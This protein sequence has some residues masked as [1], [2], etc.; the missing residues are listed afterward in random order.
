MLIP[1][2][3]VTTPIYPV[4]T[5][6]AFVQKVAEGVTSSELSRQK[7]KSKSDAQ[8]IKWNKTTAIP[9]CTAVPDTY[10]CNNKQEN[11]SRL[12]FLFEN[13]FVLHQFQCSYSGTSYIPMYCSLFL[14]VPVLYSNKSR[15]LPGIIMLILFFFS[16][17]ISDNVR[18]VSIEKNDEKTQ[19]EKAWKNGMSNRSG[20]Q[21]S[22]LNHNDSL[23]LTRRTATELP[24]QAFP[25]QPR[26][27]PRT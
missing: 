17:A 5:A 25:T 11:C 26:P 8:K 13:G 3:A 22:L 9:L 2:G 24:P 20:A 16:F 23:P 18:R 15:N 10:T 4:T 21:K 14:D 7:E 12:D 6:F 1:G 27:D 19:H